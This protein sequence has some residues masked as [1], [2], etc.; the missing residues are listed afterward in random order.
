[1]TMTEELRNYEYLYQ[2]IQ[3]PVLKN[4]IKYSFEYYIKNANFYKIMGTTLSIAGIALPAAATFLTAFTN[5]CSWAIA[6][7]T[8]LATIASGTLAH[9][10]CAEKKAS[11]RNSAENMKSELTAYASKHGAYQKLTDEKSRDSL[12]FE[13]IERIIQDGY[14]KISDLERNDK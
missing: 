2:D 9:L 1:M 3:D 8:A 12:L 14:K 6:L 10:K 7:F 13:N 11:Y 5:V 4:R